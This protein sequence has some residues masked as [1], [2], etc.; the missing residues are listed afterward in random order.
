MAD[1]GK[2][3]TKEVVGLVWSLPAACRRSRQR[4]H[5]QSY[6]REHSKNVDGFVGHRF[7]VWLEPVMHF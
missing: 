4:R 7:L 2:E 3:D 1:S 5:Q 6:D